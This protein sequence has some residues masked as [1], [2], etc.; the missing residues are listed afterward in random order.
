MINKKRIKRTQWLDDTEYKTWVIAGWDLHKS[1]ATNNNGVRDNLLR[2][3][4]SRS[5]PIECNYYDPTGEEYTIERVEELG[6]I[7][8]T[9]IKCSDKKED[10]TR[11]MCFN[12]WQQMLMGRNQSVA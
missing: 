6:P 12:C 7:T 9:K 10:V 5:L 4:N 1:L 11:E 2:S 3:A 8:R